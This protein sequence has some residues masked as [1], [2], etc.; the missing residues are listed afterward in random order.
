[1]KNFFKNFLFVYSLLI[2]DNLYSQV[3][4][5][6]INDTLKLNDEYIVSEAILFLSHKDIDSFYESEITKVRTYYYNNML[7]EEYTRKKGFNIG[8]YRSYYPNG[9]LN[10]FYNCNDGNRVDFYLEFYDNGLKKVAG[11]YNIFKESPHFI[12]KNDTVSKKDS[13]TG[14]IEYIITASPFI[15]DIKDGPWYYWDRTGI[16]IKKELWKRGKL[17]LSK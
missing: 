9:K 14:F 16:L 17:I 7:K 4:V 5:D 6:L 8:E 2:W 3:K 12:Y 10:T 11:R 13:L 1:M 15:N